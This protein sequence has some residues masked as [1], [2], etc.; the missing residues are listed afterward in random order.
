MSKVKKFIEL[1]E[2]KT[3][4]KTFCVL[5]WIHVATRPN[6][7]AR[8]CCGANASQATKGIMDGGLVKNSDGTPA[9]FGKD[10]FSSSWNNE[11]MRNVRTAMLSGNVPSSC[12]KCFE[13]E[14]NGI[15]SK[16]VWETYYWHEEGI[17]LKKLVDDT[18]GDG[19][20][21]AAIRYLD[22]RLGHTCNLK[23]VMCSPHD[24][25]RWV[26]DYDNLVSK[27]T[28]KVV[29]NQI[30]WDKNKFNNTWYERPEL[31]DV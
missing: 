27:T 22:L 29:L 2:N 14:T 4:S 18:T 7:D 20:V 23:C 6:G 30:S 19:E 17:D 15:V 25:S 9:N 11:Y 10:S 3:G 5:P 16:R 28:S 8:L 1:V 21:P 24:S 13:E 12:L 31:W 26:Q